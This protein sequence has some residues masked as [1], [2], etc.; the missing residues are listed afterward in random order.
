[1]MLQHNTTLPIEADRSSFHTLLLLCGIIGSAMFAIVNFTLAA[2]NPDYNIVSQTM[3]DLE[4]SDHGW[5]Q[6]TNFIV[7]GI[8]LCAYAWGLRKELVSGLGAVTIPALQLTLGITM[9]LL[10]VF[11][12]DAIHSIVIY[13]LFLAIMISFFIF[14]RRFNADKRWIHWA[15]YTN[16]TAIVLLI[17]FALYIRSG[18][19]HSGY[20]GIYQRGVLLTR[21]IWNLFFTTRLLAGAKLYPAEK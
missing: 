16:I 1:M 17:F 7:A 21:V 9:I 3:G 19:H 2:I 8:F 11:V 4:L 14:S 15:V 13:V 20:T 5:I 12:V 10:G 18:L 6:S